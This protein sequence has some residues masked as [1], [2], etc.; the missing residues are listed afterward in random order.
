MQLPSLGGHV[1]PADPRGC[2][3]FTRR[4]GFVETVAPARERRGGFGCAASAVVEILA[5]L[6]G[7][8]ELRVKAIERCGEGVQ[9]RRE[10]L[11]L[12]S[13]ALRDLAGRVAQHQSQ[14]A[15][16]GA[17]V[18]RGVRK[19]GDLARPGAGGNFGVAREFRELARRHLL[20]EEERCGVREL[21]GLVEDHGVARGQELG[22]PLVAQHDIGEEEVMIDDDHVRVERSFPGLED[23][24]VAVE[25]A[26]AAEA[27]FAGGRDE[28]PEGCVLRDV[29]EL[30]AVAGL[31]RARKRDDLRQM[32]RVFPGRQAPFRRGTL[33]VMVADVVRASFEQRKRHRN[34][35]RIADLRQVPLVELV[36]Q[37]LGARRDDDLAAV[38]QR[39]HEVGERLAGAR[40]GLGE[41]GDARGDRPG[42]GIGHFKLLRAEPESRERARES[43][44]FAE[45]RG[46]TRIG[47]GRRRFRGCCE[48][49]VA[50]RL[51]FS[52]V[53]GAAGAAV[54]R[55][56]TTARI[57]L[58]PAMRSLNLSYGSSVRALYASS[59]SPF[60]H[61]SSTIAASQ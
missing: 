58:I 61:P 53:A 24:A 23:E 15:D 36:L 54:V 48:D 57:S 46:E 7:M 60:R 30:A 10:P 8:R 21:M 49:G 43:T 39:G 42:D 38:E 56:F 11:A 50:Q 14:P 20:S 19:C 28:R 9:F 51:A 12:G 16:R 17:D 6:G 35:Q 41:E 34:P 18:R 2:F 5:A 32:T 55:D 13:Q 31:A 45:D 3:P 44:A 47:A 4:R 22:E 52:R 1:D 33:E 25:R 26:A 40:A 59:D 37:R 27:I 29:G